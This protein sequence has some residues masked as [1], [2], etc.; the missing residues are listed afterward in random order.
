MEIAMAYVLM[1][2]AMAYMVLFGYALSRPRIPATFCFMGVLLLSAVWDASYFAELLLPSLEDKVSARLFR[3]V[4]LSW[5]PLITFG[6]VCNLFD[7]GR[8][9][10]RGVWVALAWVNAGWAVLVATAR[11]HPWFI[12]NFRIVP[13]G[14]L[15]VVDFELRFLG[16]A[17]HHYQHLLVLLPL[18]FLGH[19]IL[20]CRGRRRQNMALVFVGT[21]LPVIM[22]ILYIHAAGPRSP[23]N[24][25][26]FTTIFST[27]AFSWVILRNRGLDLVPL[28]RG[29]LLD[30]FPDPVVVTDPR[31][32]IADLNPAFAAVLGLSPRD[33]QGRELSRL[34]G[35]WPG[36]FTRADLP[37]EAQA[38]DPP[39]WLE[40]TRLLLRG[41]DG[42][43][44]GTL[45]IFHDVTEPRQRE[46]QRVEL[47]RLRYQARA[48]EQQARLL[49]DMHD[50]L[51][52]ISAN[53][54]L[55]A[56]LGRSESEL[57]EKNSVLERIE[58]L[59]LE[60]NAE[61][62]SLM[63]TLERSEFLWPD[64]LD[65]VRKYTETLCE[66]HPV[67]FVFAKEGDIP[68][69]TLPLTAGLSIF[70]MVKEALHNALR[71]ARASEVRILFRF[72]ASAL[73]IEI[74]DNG[75]GFDAS[76]VRPG[77]GLR[78]M[79]RRA[80]ELG[81]QFAISSQAGTA[82]VFHLPLPINYLTPELDTIP[83]PGV[84]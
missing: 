27:A 12:G 58:S 47:E 9:I 6:M 81:G 26:P 14:P 69:G 8:W 77:R 75:S 83:S 73:R 17:Y 76:A 79:A 19:G 31:G 66:G 18:L 37:F 13:F 40:R 64:L 52:A 32:R 55:Q 5:L 62:R 41:E 24:I 78:N 50:G 68:K 33:C 35:E 38:S 61:I 4:F 25:A 2:A 28:A 70:R 82:C 74:A 51:G 48:R 57:A 11:L 56:N 21:A 36:A 43:E 39:R 45:W 65:E 34:P 67:T 29:V 53:I 80:E 22:N 23:V 72:Q 3:T 20:R 49:R 16:E 15:G 60:G 42:S 54:S 59:A 84:G 46:A 44:A 1:L 63:N 30:H 71:H 10:P 7:L